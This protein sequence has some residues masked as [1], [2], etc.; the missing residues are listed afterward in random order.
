MPGAEPLVY[1][2][3]QF[4]PASAARLSIYDQGIVLGATVTD[5]LRTFHQ[6][7]YRLQDHIR[8]FYD[9]CK[10]ARMEP[11]L[12]PD[13]LSE[14]TRE[15]VS[16]N[17]QLLPEGGEL[18]VIYFITP[19]ENRVYTGSAAGRASPMQSTFCVH[20]FP[21]PFALFRQFFTDGLHL[22]TP[23]TRHVPPQC[24]D[25]KIKHRS[26]LH[27]W[28]AEQEAR[29]VDPAAIP[30]LLD[31]DGNLAETSGANFLLVRDGRV[32]SP[33][34][35]NILLGVS[36]QVVIELCAQLSMPFLERDLQLHDALTAD[37]AFTATTPYC[38]APVTRINGIAIGDGRPCAPVFERL[39]AAWS[40]QVGVDIR[41]QIL[42]QA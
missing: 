6:E 7:P 39:L 19:G 30:L 28:L 33:P 24:L 36:R 11:P 34:P 10:Y 14:V 35:R 38:M 42:G 2:G 13:E 8:R 26:R 27:W 15:L 1:L 5:Q 21:L 22:V 3:G 4:V 40:T 9:S 41:G 20:S 37:E 23:P 25:P 12:P 32:L 16:H 31:L 29:L 18:G 17:A